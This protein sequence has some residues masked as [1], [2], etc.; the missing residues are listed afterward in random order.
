MKRAAIRRS[1]LCA[2]EL[3]C[4]QSFSSIYDLSTLSVSRLALPVAVTFEGF[5]SFVEKTGVSLPDPTPEG[6]TLRHAGR[7][8]VLYND[9]T[10]N[11]RRLSFTLAHELGHIMLAH[12]GED[13]EREERE[14]NAFAASLLSPAIVFHYLRFRDGRAPSVEEM[15]ATFPLSREAATNRRRDLCRKRP[16]H[17]ADCE[18]ALLLH[19]FG[20]LPAAL[21]K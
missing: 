1:E 11:G 12:A 20:K 13:R 17:P 21:S 2:V 6:L 7:Y 8:F 4:A 18:I 10:E 9:R 19:L 15:T 16:S 5:S 14:A 3:L